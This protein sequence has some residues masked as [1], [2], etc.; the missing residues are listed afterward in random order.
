MTPTVIGLIGI[1]ILLLLFALRVPI[2]FAMALVGF[3]GFAYLSGLKPA[4]GIIGTVPFRTVAHYSISVILLLSTANA[5]KT[6]QRLIAG[7][8]CLGSGGWCWV[9]T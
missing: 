3:A 4:L 7:G 1:G 9:K 8:A 2:A 6:K 5:P